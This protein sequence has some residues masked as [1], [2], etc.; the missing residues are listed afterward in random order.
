MEAT[1]SVR[2]A[3]TEVIDLLVVGD[4]AGVERLTRGRRVAA[5]DLRRVVQEHGRTLVRLPDGADDR[6]D[7]TAVLGSRPPRYFV[8][9]NLQTEEEGRS[10]LTLTLEL[11]SAGRDVYEV[12]VVDLRVQ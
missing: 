9:V 2:R 10:D 5:A 4:H 3:V 6:F 1:R 12:S 8:D 7:V 11:V